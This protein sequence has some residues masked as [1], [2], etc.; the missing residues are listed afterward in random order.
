M[1]L[2]FMMLV[3]SLV[4]S[5]WGQSLDP[6]WNYLSSAEQGANNVVDNAGAQGRGVAMEA[7]QAVLNAIAAFRAA[8]ADDLKKTEESLSVEQEELFQKIKASMA[9]LND[10]TANLQQMSNTLAI[11]VSNTVIGKDIPRVTK[12]GPLYMVEGLGAAQEIVVQG[13]GLA[14]GA[15]AL[16]IDGKLTPPNTK[17]DTE[18]RFPLPTHASPEAKPLLIKAVLHL[19]ENKAAFL[20]F[21]HA[22]HPHDYPVRLAIYPREI[23]PFTVT[24]RRNVRHT[25]SVDRTSD[26]YRC[27]SPHGDE[28]NST[29]ANIVPTPGYTMVN[30]VFHP[31]D[32][33]HGTFTM[34]TTSPSGSTGTLSCYGWGKKVVMGATVD[35]GQVGVEEGWFTW[36]ERK[37]DYALQND[38]PKTLSLRWGESVAVPDLPADTQTV[39]FELMPFT[40]QTLD[41]EGSG[42]NRFARLDF[43]GVSKV[44]TVTAREVEQ[45]LHQ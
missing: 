22:L 28:S 1:R 25:D 41:M 26:K 24:A 32:S 17:T 7:G 8:Y 23:G 19:Y 34:N 30:L 20:G 5:A 43:N 44:A 14:N 37:D 9:L 21:W 2:A 6:I 13:L 33:N 15:P 3:G 45:A 29:S 4:G 40:G 39:L 42:S 10:P 12:V 27:E 16:E 31:S 35:A 18:I 11:A 36:N 38:P